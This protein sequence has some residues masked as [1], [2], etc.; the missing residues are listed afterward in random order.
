MYKISVFLGAAEVLHACGNDE[1]AFIMAGAAEAVC[2]A[3][4]GKESAVACRCRAWQA[5]LLSALGY[6][7]E[8][9]WQKRTVLTTLPALPEEEEKRIR[10][11]LES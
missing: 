7:E 5:V 8:A 4:Y 11:I 1:Q 9:E 6:A 2:E 10:N 3:H